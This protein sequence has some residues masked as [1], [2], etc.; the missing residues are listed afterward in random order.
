M[1][2]GSSPPPA[3]K[4]LSEPPSC[5]RTC[6]RGGHAAVHEGSHVSPWV[7]GPWTLQDR[8]VMHTSSMVKVSIGHS[9]CKLLC[10]KGACR[11]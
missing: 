7:G 8:L 1:V 11:P 5:T 9:P 3:H 2:S 10:R 4:V 6:L